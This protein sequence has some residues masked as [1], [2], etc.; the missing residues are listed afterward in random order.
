MKN[1]FKRLRKQTAGVILMEYVILGFLV[2]TM[3]I[4]AVGTF[5]KTISNDFVTLAVA[6]LGDGQG[7][8]VSA[9]ANLAALTTAMNEIDAYTSFVGWAKSG[10]HDGFSSATADYYTWNGMDM[11]AFSRP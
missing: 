2:A 3:A 5:G 6:S 11:A 7:A 10:A 8:L 1:L 4:A 9:S